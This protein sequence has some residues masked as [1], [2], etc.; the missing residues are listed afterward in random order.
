MTRPCD[1][2][3]QMA[4]WLAATDIEE[5][6]LTGPGCRLRLRHEG[7]AVV[8]SEL[9]G[10]GAQVTTSA[11]PARSAVTADRPGVF[12]HRHP[13][14][15]D[16]LIEAGERVVTGQVLGLLRVGPLLFPLRAPVAGIV[17]GM[18]MPHEAIVGFGT[19]L[20][21]LDTTQGDAQ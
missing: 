17:I 5:L 21:E 14:R 18:W 20:V 19:K 13:L 12:L 4:D 9:V 1:G 16:A 10:A 15:T 7:G 2:A 11:V 3:G 6:E 8:R